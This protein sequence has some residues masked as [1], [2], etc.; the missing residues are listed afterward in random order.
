MPPYIYFLDKIYHLNVDP[1]GG[2]LSMPIL[3]DDWSPFL[4]LSSIFEG[5]D[6]ILEEPDVNYPASE[7]LR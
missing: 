7:S 5:I 4:T 2:Q 1:I 6:N 3:S